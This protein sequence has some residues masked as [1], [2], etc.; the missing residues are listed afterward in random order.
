[1]NDFQF[2]CILLTLLVFRC[3]V[4][5]DCIVSGTLPFFNSNTKLRITQIKSVK[6]FQ[7]FINS[8]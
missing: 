6:P 8:T 4:D 5:L 2:A 1:M 7:Y 3:N